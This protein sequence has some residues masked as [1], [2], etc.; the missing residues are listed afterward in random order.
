MTKGDEYVK[1]VEWS[2]EDS[3]FIGSY[4]ELFYGGCHRNDARGVFDELCQIVDE[5]IALYE[6][7]G[8]PLPAPLSGKDFVNAMQGVQG[9]A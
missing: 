4:P 9:T 7:D 1:I 8:K 2:D 3:C 5:T 6:E